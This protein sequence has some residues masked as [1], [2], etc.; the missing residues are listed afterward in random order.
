MRYVWSGGGSL[1]GE[2]QA[3]V[4]I[5]AFNSIDVIKISVNDSFEINLLALSNS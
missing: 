3:L 5:I 4:V 1:A 2:D